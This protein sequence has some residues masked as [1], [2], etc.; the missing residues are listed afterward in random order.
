MQRK[1]AKM[2]WKVSYLSDKDIIHLEVAGVYDATNGIAVIKA[3]QAEAFR[4]KLHYFQE[5]LLERSRHT[6]PLAVFHSNRPQICIIVHQSYRDS[7]P[8]L[9]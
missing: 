2:E 6:V 5:Y 4:R 8:S 3:V 9:R 1:G 7:I